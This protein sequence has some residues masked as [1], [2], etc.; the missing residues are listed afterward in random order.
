MPE[1]VAALR[2]AAELAPGNPRYAY[3]YAVA[4]EGVEGV[5]RAVEVLERAQ[6]SHPIDR[7]LLTALATYN[8]QRGDQ[9]TAA[10]SA[11]GR[12]GE[13][14]EDPRW[15]RRAARIEGRRRPVPN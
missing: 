3:V 1:A 12:V 11:R 14:P 8:E 7:D 15:K 2:R 6:E 9:A 4:L 10:R 5:A 13:W